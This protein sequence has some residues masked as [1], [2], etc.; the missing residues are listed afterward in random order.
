MLT[1]DSIVQFAHHRIGQFPGY[2][3]ERLTETGKALQGFAADHGSALIGWKLP[4]VILEHDHVQNGGHA[5]RGIGCD[6]IHL[7]AL[8]RGVEQPQ[9]HGHWSALNS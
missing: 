6:E 9:V 1:I 3:L 2:L 8:E 4:A 7:P 5:V